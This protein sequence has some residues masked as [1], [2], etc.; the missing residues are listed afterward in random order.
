MKRK[1]KRTLAAIVS[2]L[3]IVLSF[4]DYMH[5]T[6]PENIETPVMA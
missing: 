1:G 6:V 3:S 4:A 5:V 2:N